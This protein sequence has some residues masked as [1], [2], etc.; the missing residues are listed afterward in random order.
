MIP[1]SHLKYH[2]QH[3]HSN[4]DSQIQCDYPDCSQMV[5]PRSLKRHYLRVQLRQYQCEDPECVQSFRF[6][7]YAT[8]H[9]QQV[10]LKKM[11]KQ[12]TFPGCGR[13]YDQDYM[14]KHFQT[15]HSGQVIRIQCEYP[16]C[17]KM[18]PTKEGC[19]RHYRHQHCG[20]PRILHCEH[21]EWGFTG[22]L[23]VYLKHLLKAHDHRHLLIIPPRPSM[24]IADISKFRPHQKLINQAEQVIRQAE[25]VP[26]T[27]GQEPTT[28][29]MV[30]EQDSS[31]IVAKLDPRLRMAEGFPAL[32]VR[33]RNDISP[34]SINC[35]NIM[36]FSKMC[37]LLAGYVKSQCPM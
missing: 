20:Q 28:L 34:A 2:Y 25:Q 8:K 37:Q 35:H 1:S 6:K 18:Y 17:D 32:T 31:F 9:Y 10:H 11:R 26:A 33:E 13:F 14:E 36:R 16:G 5:N 23:S 27:K 19:K 12:C 22:A 3:R 15:Q 24:D 30:D 21:C 29:T 7:R 4:Q